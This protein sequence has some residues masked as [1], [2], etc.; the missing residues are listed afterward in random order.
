MR[1]KSIVI[2]LLFAATFLVYWNVGNCFISLDDAR[3]ITQNSHVATGLTKDNII[4]AFTKTYESNWHP[5][6]WL[7][8]MTDCQL[9]GLNPRGHHLTNIF[10][11]SLNAALLFLL[12]IKMTGARWRS[13]F[14]AALFALHPLHVESVAWIAERKDVLSG[15]FWMLTLLGYAYYA[16]RPNLKRYLLTFFAFALGLMAKPMLVTLPV[17]ML[18]LDYWP[19]KRT[20]FT[21]I[22]A[23]RSGQTPRKTN[24]TTLSLL[25]AEKIPFF[26]LSAV[27]SAITFYAQKAGGSVNPI[28]WIP[29]S[30][31]VVNSLLSYIAYIKQMLWP[32]GL[33]IFYP[34]PHTLTV[35]QGLAPGLLLLAISVG[36]VMLARKGPYFFTGWFWYIITLLPV[37]GLVQVGQQARADRYTYLP[38]IGIF[39]II[40]W[41]VPALLGSWKHRKS[42]L[43]IF[44]VIVLLL[45]AAATRHQV[46]F[47]KNDEALF[48]HAANVTNNNYVAYNILGYDFFRQKK[49]AE[50][51]SNF[52]EALRLM[53][54]DPS[55]RLPALSPKSETLTGMGLVLT[56]CGKADEAIAF[57]QK[58]IKIQPNYTAYKNLGYYFLK[59][60]KY[61]EAASNFSEALRIMPPDDAATL[62]GMGLVLTECGRSEEAIPFFQKAIKI[63]PNY[64]DARLGL[65]DAL[66]KLG[67]LDDAIEILSETAE[68]YP[69]RGDV[70]Y[71]LALELGER[72]RINEAIQHFEAA[73][74]IDPENA[75]IQCNLGVALVREGRLDEAIYHFEEAVRIRPDSEQARRSLQ[76]ALLLKKEP[77][78]PQKN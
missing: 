10:F 9:Y 16:E 6:T 69:D 55:G 13:A 42:A 37:I 27:S 7:S 48:E 3:Y 66:L 40:A 34:L 41:G 21:E 33:A 63:T 19:L 45:C 30:F 4:W 53:P 70:Q 43:A 29:I 61:A 74:R 39:I 24:A 15:M 8:H 54:D 2:I 11:H 77:K 35:G 31:R 44:A 28:K 23:G 17:I 5:L 20:S 62:A 68:M 14:V 57:F 52:S 36:A 67:R 49:Y 18:L 72:G 60:K 75:D 78:L 64:I 12:L 56:E 26:V 32:A 58:A 47:W 50:A 73:L 25:I 51:A 59:Q 46:G 65:G 22:E 38:L 71:S 76:A 1:F